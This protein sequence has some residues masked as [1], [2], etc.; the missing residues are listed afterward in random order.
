MRCCAS[1][2][3]PGAATAR[4]SL[5]RPAPVKAAASVKAASEAVREAVEVVGREAVGNGLMVARVAGDKETVSPV[6][7][8]SRAGKETAALTGNSPSNHDPNKTSRRR[9][10][11]TPPA[12]FIPHRASVPLRLRFV[13]RAGFDHVLTGLNTHR[14]GVILEG[15]RHHVGVEGR[16]AIG[17]FEAQAHLHLLDLRLVRGPGQKDGVAPADRVTALEPLE[18]ILVDAPLFQG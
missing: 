17:R 16:R 18:R 2:S 9:E 6:T 7:A 10:Y 4:P 3:W 15:D 5:A 11:L 13:L 1:K 8:A 14:N 12:L